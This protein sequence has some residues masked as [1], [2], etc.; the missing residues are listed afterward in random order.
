MK[1][2]ELAMASNTGIVDRVTAGGQNGNDKSAF[3]RS[4]F[5]GGR[6]ALGQDW[7][8]V[9]LM[10]IVPFFFFGCITSIE[11]LMIIHVV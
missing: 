2:A 7:E 5:G 6:P 10:N 8:L 9:V 11:S 4:T 1:K 3:C